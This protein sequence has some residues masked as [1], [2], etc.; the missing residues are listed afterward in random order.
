[1]DIKK[2]GFANLNHFKSIS[3]IYVE[4]RGVWKCIALWKKVYMEGNMLRWFPPNTPGQ[5][6]KTSPQKLGWL[7]KKHRHM[8][9]FMLIY[10]RIRKKIPRKH[11]KTD[12]RYNR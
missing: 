7:K 4:F 10:H 11:K 8:V 9:V 3:G 2:K 6:T 12:P 5:V 1:M